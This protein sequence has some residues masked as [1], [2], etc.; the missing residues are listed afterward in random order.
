MI[1]Y[2]PIHALKAPHSISVYVPNKCQN[3]F[4]DNIQNSNN[5]IIFAFLNL[6]KQ[7]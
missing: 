7:V 5:F 6:D 1:D 4:G 3:S 2:N